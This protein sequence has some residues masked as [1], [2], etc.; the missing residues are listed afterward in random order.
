MFKRSE[1]RDGE[2]HFWRQYVST[3]DHLDPMDPKLREKLRPTAEEL[4]AERLVNSKKG[5]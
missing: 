2:E 3:W 5:A 1:P 4:A